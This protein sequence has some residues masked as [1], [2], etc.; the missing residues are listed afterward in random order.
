VFVFIVCFSFPDRRHRECHQNNL[1]PDLAG[2]MPSREEKLFRMR[3]SV[4]KRLAVGTQFPISMNTKPFSGRMSSVLQRL[5]EP[6]QRTD[7]VWD[8]DGFRLF[9]VFGHEQVPEARVVR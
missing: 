9:L 7:A 1:L 3:L 4:K 8:F 2:A 6:L 5:G